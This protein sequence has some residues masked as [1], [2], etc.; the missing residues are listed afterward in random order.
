MSQGYGLKPGDDSS[1]FSRKWKPPQ[2]MIWDE[3]SLKSSRSFSWKEDGTMRPT[4]SGRSRDS[5]KKVA[6]RTTGIL[7]IGGKSAAEL[8]VKSRQVERRQSVVG[9]TELRAVPRLVGVG[10]PRTQLHKND[11][12]IRYLQVGADRMKKRIH[13][14]TVEN[15]ILLQKDVRF[16]LIP[17]K[18][19]DPAELLSLQS[20]AD[21]PAVKRS[22]GVIRHPFHKA[23]VANC[24][25]HYP[26][27]SR[28]A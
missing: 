25:R 20:S 24:A 26:D 9:N 15:D 6:A 11:R 21:H 16:A 5:G 27:I 17:E 3:R 8:V 19:L 28:W 13:P 7:L 2:L 4:R 23:G 12:Q 1:S 22:Q 18:A 14:L 10:R